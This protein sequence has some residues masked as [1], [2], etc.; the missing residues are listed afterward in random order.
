MAARR[1]RLPLLTG[2]LLLVLARTGYAQGAEQP[3]RFLVLP[4]TVGAAT[5]SV[6]SIAVSDAARLRI[7]NLA[8]SRVYVV[9]KD[10][11]CEALKVSGF[12][13]D[14]LLDPT[15]A[16]LLARFLS[17]QAYTT[18]QLERAGGRLTARVRVVDL[19]SSGYSSLFAV[20]DSAGS[21]PASLGD[22]IAQR[23]NTVIRAGDDARECGERRQK[24]DLNGALDAAHKALALE[25]DL[26]AAH[27]CVETIYE[28]RRMPADSLIAATQ[29]ATRGDT[30]NAS[31]W[32]ALAHL[33]QAKGDTLLAIDAF[34]RELAGDPQNQQLRLGVADLLRQQKQ[35]QR[36]VGILDEGLAGNSG[37]PHLLAL[38]QSICIEGQLWRCTL[39]G[40][41]AQAGSDSTRLADSAFL[42]AALGAAQQL[43]DTTELLF[44]GHAAVHAFPKSP[45]FWKVLGSAFLGRGEADSALVADRHAVA[46]EPGDAN[47]A[48]LLAKTL[49]D[50]TLYDT[51]AAN[52]LKPDT[53]A[54]RALRDT[55]ATR[56]DSARAALAPALNGDSTQRLSAAVLLLTGGSRLAQAGAYARAYDWL[57]QTLAIVAPR[58]PPTRSG[59]ASKCGCRRASGSGSRPS[60]RSPAR[61]PTW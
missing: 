13:C 17:V 59:R 37:E 57:T 41:V 23:L 12:T 5:D 18:G 27:L 38:K 10:K 50:V 36:A 58:A 16:R 56:M 49:V 9:P 31:A 28:A 24:S 30:L 40:F 39:D 55:F 61:M 45:E 1:L 8:H 51:A 22:A 21:A 54:L 60:P 20:A 19:G 52:R 47:A 3:P 4:L 14:I 11:L 29:R 53:I 2:A 34:T 32:D 7:E 46:L 43:G 44:F 25:P 48:L 33:Y 26:P 15:S 35:Y 42:K 6:T